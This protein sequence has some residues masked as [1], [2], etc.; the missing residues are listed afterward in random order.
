MRIDTQIALTDGR[1][2]DSSSLEF[3]ERA[4][5]TADL[6]DD[7]ANSRPESGWEEVWDAISAITQA[8]ARLELRGVEFDD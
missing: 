1:V 3:R 6:F 8:L 2:I 4:P 5:I 7:L